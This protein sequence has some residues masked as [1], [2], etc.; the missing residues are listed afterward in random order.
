M[1]FKTNLAFE[2]ISNK[3][4][5]Y[6]YS[7]TDKKKII[8]KYLLKST[9]QTDQYF[10]NSKTEEVANH[11]FHLLLKLKDPNLDSLGEINTFEAAITNEDFLD[12][13]DKGDDAVINSF[14]QQCGVSQTG[15]DLRTVAP[16]YGVH[17]TRYMQV[18][19]RFLIT[20]CDMIRFGSFE[21]DFAIWV[22]GNMV[23]D[24]ENKPIKLSELIKK[25][26]FN[27]ITFSQ[28]ELHLFEAWL[29]V[30]TT[31]HRFIESSFDTFLAVRNL[32]PSNTPIG[33]DMLTQGEKQAIFIYTDAGNDNTYM[34]RLMQGRIKDIVSSVPQMKIPEFFDKKIKALLLVTGVCISALNKLPHFDARKTTSSYC[35]RYDTGLSDEEYYRRVNAVKEKG[36]VTLERSLISTSHTK[37]CEAF[38]HGSVV[39]LFTL[40]K[41]KLVQSYS[42][43]PWEREVI[44]PPTMIRWHHYFCIPCKGKNKH[45]FIAETVDC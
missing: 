40:S 35:Y 31:Q 2:K 1:S 38:G 14:I 28:Q 21:N 36:G 45:V 11:Y 39:T 8:I 23:T 25:T 20:N 6:D 15:L 26:N 30:V 43:S 18:L 12:A 16:D 19:L 9:T 24:D 7:I 41:G 22:N 44:I 3:Q 4:E 29:Y 33:P 10:V 5:L 32:N 34:I 17:E 13:I 27:A 42:I 37:P